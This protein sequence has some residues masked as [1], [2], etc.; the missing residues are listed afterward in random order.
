MFRQTSHNASKLYRLTDTCTLRLC[1]GD[2]TSFQVCL[3]A[4]SYMHTIHPES[5]MHVDGDDSRRVWYL[6]KLQR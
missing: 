2:I 5:R 3:S 1:I 6:K 4:S